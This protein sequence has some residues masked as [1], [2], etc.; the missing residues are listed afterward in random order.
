MAKGMGRGLCCIR[1][2]A[3]MKV[4]GNVITSRGLVSNNFL[5]VVFI[6]GNISMVSRRVSVNILGVMVNFIR[7]NG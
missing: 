2:N 6:M 7:D 1:I 3:F 5:T 4:I